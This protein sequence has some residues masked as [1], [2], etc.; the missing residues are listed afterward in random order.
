MP[1]ERQCLGWSQRSTRHASR[2]ICPPQSVYLYS[3][4]SAMDKWLS[5][6]R[7]SGRTLQRL[8]QIADASHHID[9][10]ILPACFF[11]QS[12]VISSAP[13]FS[14]QHRI[15]PFDGLKWLIPL[16]TCH[17]GDRHVATTNCRCGRF[18]PRHLI[19]S[20]RRFGASDPCRRRPK[21]GSNRKLPR[22]SL[23]CIRPNAQ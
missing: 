11:A 13:C 8:R 12:A 10:L 4:A 20:N 16:V 3:T 22:R 14:V 6:S 7:R 21:L 9:S 17:L 1:N 19:L 2:A 18:R 15:S 23:D 5:R